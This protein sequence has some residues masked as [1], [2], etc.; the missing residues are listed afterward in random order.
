MKRKAI[1]LSLSSSLLSSAA[2]ETLQLQLTGMTPHV[3]QMFES[4]LVD[5]STGI[6]AGRTTVSAIPSA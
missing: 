3:G 4:R 1:V 6:E 2:S 5:L